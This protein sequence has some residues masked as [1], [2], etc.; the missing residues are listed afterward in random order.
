MKAGTGTIGT[1]GM[2][3][4]RREVAGMT[5]GATTTRMGIGPGMRP[6]GAPP[7]SIAPEGG[8]ISRLVDLN[9]GRRVAMEAMEEAV[10]RA[11]GTMEAA[12][13]AGTTTTKTEGKLHHPVINRVNSSTTFY[14]Y[15]S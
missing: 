15:D 13:A 9:M 1:T 10:T 5:T 2:R 12:V 7:G 6:T 4:T 8:T 14:E 3:G 11:G